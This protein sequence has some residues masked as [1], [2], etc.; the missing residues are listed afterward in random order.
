MRIRAG[1]NGPQAARPVTLSTAIARC[2]VLVRIGDLPGM[3]QVQP[4]CGHQALGRS[5]LARH[6]STRFRFSG[7]RRGGSAKSTRAAR[8]PST[9]EKNSGAAMSTPTRAGFGAPS[10]L[11]SHTAST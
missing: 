3:N 6:T 5:P 2:T 10:K 1:A 9:I 11:P 4:R 7:Q 8:S